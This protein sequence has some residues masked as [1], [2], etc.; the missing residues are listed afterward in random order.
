M[1]YCNTSSGGPT[2]LAQKLARNGGLLHPGPYTPPPRQ[3]QDTEFWQNMERLLWRQ[4]L[5]R[6]ASRKLE[7]ENCVYIDKGL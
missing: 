7:V 1:F 2:K 5:A 3:L 6:I 4:S